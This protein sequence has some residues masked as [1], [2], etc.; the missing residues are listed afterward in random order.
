MLSI[1]NRSAVPSFIAFWPELNLPAW[2]WNWGRTAQSLGHE[3]KL[4]HAK[5]VK[6]YVRQTKTDAA[7][8]DALILADRDKSLHPIPVKPEGLQ[9]LQGLHKIREQWKRARVARIF[10]A[11]ALLAEFDISTPV[12]VRG[13]GVTIATA[14]VAR[15][16]TT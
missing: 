4:L 6:A 1:G 16:S 13:I 15:V 12:G 14:L 3:V 2:S 8:A 11:R 9:A 7:D 5:Y 10:E